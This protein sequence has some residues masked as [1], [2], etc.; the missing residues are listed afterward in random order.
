MAVKVTAGKGMRK[1]QSFRELVKA[2]GP[3]D[4]VRSGYALHDAGEYFRTQMMAEEIN[5]NPVGIDTGNL[6]LSYAEVY[7]D[8]PDMIVIKPNLSKASYAP[9]VAT[10]TRMKHG[11][12]FTELT[13]RRTVSLADT[14]LGDEIKRAVSVI[15]GGGL[16]KYENPFPYVPHAPKR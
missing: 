12:T 11:L 8:T 13:L 9:D 14:H 15:G 3:G 5:F 10:R 6:R 16:Y 1:L 7:Q 4:G 2:F